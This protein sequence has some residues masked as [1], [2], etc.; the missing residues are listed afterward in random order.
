[1]RTNRTPPDNLR[2]R[3]IGLH[4]RA[5]LAILLS[6]SVLL[7]QA[8]INLR[9]MQY[10]LLNFPE[11][12]PAGKADTLA[13]ILAYHPVD[14]LFCEEIRTEAGADA[15]LADALNIAGVT[16]FSMAA[17]EPQ[18]SDPGS[19]YDLQQIIYYDHDKLGLKEQGY[20]ITT[21]RDLN[22]Y[23]LYP[24]TPDLPITNDTLFFTVYAVHLKAG[25]TASDENDR[26]DM[27]QGLVDHI[28]T[29][30]PGRPVMVAGDM[31]FYSGA[32]DAYQTIVDDANAID[33]DDPLNSAAG[34]SGSSFYASMHT[35]STR[36]NQIFGDGS[37]GGLDDRFDFVFLSADFFDATSP[38]QLVPGSY[39]PLGNSGDCFNGSVQYCDTALTPATIL[40]SL[41]YMSDHLPV[42]LEVAIDPALA[43][44]PVAAPAGDLSIVHNSDGSID[45]RFA[46]ATDAGVLEVIDLS[47]RA[48]E[49]RSVPR[50][51][52]R[53]DGV[54]A[55]LPCGGYTIVLRDAEG[56]RTMRWVK[57]A[58]R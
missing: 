8:Q 7:T 58:F 4:M 23:T 39:R 32:E 22:W 11:P 48:V 40:Q 57:A 15:V 47:G 43:I 36:I 17:W 45:L 46:T 29:L 52:T 24:I 6:T 51:S 33:V 16:R 53:I 1:M 37:G 44:G 5:T 35:Q 49:S 38:F 26:A 56:T 18:H 41:Y 20:V 34:W 54:G 30:Q 42:V 28:A 31:N 3:Q 27:A 12:N 14:L 21:V 13:K 19:T 9:V 2:P 50:G 25:S 55:A 10:N